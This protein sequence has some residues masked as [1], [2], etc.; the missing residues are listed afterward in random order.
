[1]KT[2]D[3][4]KSEELFR[5]L[6]NISYDISLVAGAVQ[7]PDFVNKDN[8]EETYNQFIL[9]YENCITRLSFVKQEISLLYHELMN[10]KAYHM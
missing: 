10:N 8:A 5:E 6:K 3:R 4:N 9:Q 7:N 1:M 2:L